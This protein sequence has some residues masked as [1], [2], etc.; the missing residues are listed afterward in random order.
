[1]RR[2]RPLLRSSWTWLTAGIL[3]VSVISLIGAGGSDPP[4]LDAGSARPDGALALRLWLERI[5][6]QVDVA[7]S[8]PDVAS[9]TPS[10]TVALLAGGSDV[11]RGDVSPLLHWVRGGGHVVVA[12]SGSTAGNLLDRLG[13]GIFGAATQTVRVDQP[14]LLAPP[15]AAL[16]G[17][18]TAVV[19]G[20][21][22]D[23]EVAS[24]PD[25]AV[26]L[27]R[28]LGRGA[29]WVL[30]APALLDNS[31][32]A[33]AGNRRLALNLSGPRGTSVLLDQYRVPAPAST[34]NWFT[35][36][37][38]GVALSFLIA[39]L[40][41]FRWL[42]GWRL[43]P[44]VTPMRFQFRPATEYIVSLAGLLRRGRRRQDVLAMY[45]SSLRRLIR[46]R[47]GDLGDARIDRA[48]RE[49]LTSLL[50][51]PPPLSESDLVR[52]A[53]AIVQEEE[54]IRGER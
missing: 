20:A 41:L 47:Y 29:I 16:D 14:L 4:A 36:T 6:Y 18:T 28:R 25:G 7:G 38:W 52:R 1:M 17:A 5:G 27:L 45:Q 32:I 11:E 8:R 23:V 42:G 9:L 30:S 46:R 22:T 35:S 10:G 21:A 48:H 2:T 43:G 13:I 3:L 53:A 44:A 51:P 49:T 19:Q 24:G 37:A 40:V 50:Q 34:G 12:S 54:R 33:L 39:V 15:V 31:H 26:L